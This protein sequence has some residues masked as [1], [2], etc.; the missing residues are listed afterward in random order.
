MKRSLVLILLILLT[1]VSAVSASSW[2][3]WASSAPIL[4]KPTWNTSLWPQIDFKPSFPSQRP[5]P[6]PPATPSNPGSPLLP[7]QPGRPPKEITPP[8]VSSLTSEEQNLINQVNR[9]RVSGGLKTLQVDLNLVA[10]AKE[11]SRDMAVAGYFDHISPNLG[12]VYNMLNRAGISYALA[13]ENIA[14]TGSFA[15]IHPLFMGSSAHRAN[16][17]YSGY[18]HI[19][20]GIFQRGTSYYTTQ[21]FIKK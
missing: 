21:I 8:P 13:G 20:V 19:G 2:D 18:T 9:E 14:R 1:A 4:P 10:L 7:V 17:M 12:S 15:R 16:I 3:W 6:T 5:Q 11:K